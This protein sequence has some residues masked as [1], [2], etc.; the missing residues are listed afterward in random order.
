MDWEEYYDNF[1][2]MDESAR[3]SAISGI[4]T[5][6]VG[7]EVC[8]LAESFED[9]DGATVLVERMLSLGAGFHTDEIQALFELVSPR[10]YSGLLNSNTV[11]YSEEDLEYFYGMVD[12]E[13]IA[14]IAAKS[15]ISAKTGGVSFDQVLRAAGVAKNE[16][17]HS[18]DCECGC[19]H[20]HNE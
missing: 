10:V 4:A 11:P 3:I 15:G 19:G 20:G 1:Y 6:G 13:I 9:D 8:E 5:I 14:D 7:E 2:D 18:H 16:S 12:D 17:D